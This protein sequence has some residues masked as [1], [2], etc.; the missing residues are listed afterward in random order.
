MAKRRT[1]EA[2]FDDLEKKACLTDRLF[3]EGHEDE[4]RLLCC[5]YIEALG[6]GLNP[7]NPGGAQNF[8]TVLSDHGGEP[9]LCLIHPRAL[10]NSLPYKSIAPGSRTAVQTFL[11]KLP[12]NEALT[13]TGLIDA[14]RPELLTDALSFLQRELWRGTIAAIA[15]SKIRS[16]GAHWFASPGSVRFS[17]TTYQG[18]PIPEV[19]FSMLRRALGRVL[20]D[21]KTLSLNTNRWFGHD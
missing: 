20:Q 8:A 11:N 5:C 6:N 3:S 18:D 21:A 13:E 15:Y 4:A 9:M 17:Q 2:F 16:L 10:Q 1:I 12:A 7:S 14:A 19:D